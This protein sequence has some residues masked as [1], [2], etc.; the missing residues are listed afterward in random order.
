MEQGQPASGRIGFSIG[1]QSPSVPSREVEVGQSDHRSHDHSGVHGQWCSP[2]WQGK[3]KTASGYLRSLNED[4]PRGV[5]APR[6]GERVCRP[7]RGRRRTNS[8]SPCSINVRGAPRPAATT[9]G[10][11]VMPL[12]KMRP[13]PSGV[14]RMLPKPTEAWSKTL[15][16]VRPSPRQPP[17][18]TA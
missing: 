4:E 12:V 18:C 15:R 3:L 17:T 13:R 6:V 8:S 10:S 2:V 7:A 1:A 5:N 9:Q 16:V 11:M 14:Q